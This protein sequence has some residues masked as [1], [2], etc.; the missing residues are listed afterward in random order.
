MGGAA[1]FFLELTL[2]IDFKYKL[3]M[4]MGLGHGNPLH[5]AY[6]AQYYKSSARSYPRLHHAWKLSNREDPSQKSVLL[7][8][9]VTTIVYKTQKVSYNNSVTSY[10]ISSAFVW[11]GGSM[12][13]M[14]PPWIRHAFSSGLGVTLQSP[15]AHE[16]F[17]I[18]I[19]F[20]L[21]WTMKVHL[22]T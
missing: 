14:E 4:T 12:E 1:G 13:P 7:V 2:F 19:W 3:N 5:L 8:T 22:T 10:I 11:K 18:H 15:T 21:T 6:S 9:K 16:L 20:P 17:I